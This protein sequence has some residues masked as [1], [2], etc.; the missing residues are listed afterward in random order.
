M[1]HLFGLE[2]LKI[3]PKIALHTPKETILQAEFSKFFA[4]GVTPASSPCTAYMDMSRK[5]KHHRPPQ[6]SS[7]TPKS[8]KPV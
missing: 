1:Q 3:S 7:N 4:R 6:T 2:H 5:C 8:R